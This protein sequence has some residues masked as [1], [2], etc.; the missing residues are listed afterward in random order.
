MM[1]GY[2]P[3]MDHGGWFSMGLFRVMLMG[4]IIWAVLRPLPT[5]QHAHA[6]ASA[7]ETLKPSSTTAPEQGEVT[8]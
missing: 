3:G 7:R 4:V 2:V 8:P 1:G 6:G 5:R